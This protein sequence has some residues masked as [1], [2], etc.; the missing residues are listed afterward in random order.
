[1]NEFNKYIQKHNKIIQS[2]SLLKVYKALKVF[3]INSFKE[4][5]FTFSLKSIYTRHFESSN[6]HLF[7]TI[8]T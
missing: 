6:I 3:L 2:W 1:M 5:R 7:L 8:L 4:G